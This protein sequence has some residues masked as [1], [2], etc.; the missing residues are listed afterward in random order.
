MPGQ[1]RVAAMH[2]SAKL[3][4]ELGAPLGRMHSATLALRVASAS[5]K[6]RAF[7]RWLGRTLLV[8][9]VAGASL[10]GCSIYD[11]PLL[12][13]NAGTSG[14]DSGTAGMSSAGGS[15]SSNAGDSSAGNSAGGQSE[16][17]AAG[18]SSGGRAGVGG[19]AD[20]S[21]GAAGDVGAGASSGNSGG[22]GGSAGGTAQAGNSGAG[23]GALV[24]REL[25]KGKKSTASTEQSGNEAVKGNDGD[26]DTRW[27]AS[28]ESYPQWWRVDLG[29][30]HQVVRVSIKFEHPER[31]YWY[32]IETSQ[33]DAVYVQ[34]AA[35]SGGT[36]RVQMVELPSNVTARY[37]RITL[38]AG[39]GAVDPTWA[40]FFEFAVTGA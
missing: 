11:A 40:S 18:D 10:L 23:G 3:K 7:E 14:D 33:D 28:S 13:G 26:S 39:S 35:L 30:S 1:G 6:R 25:A 5:S 31:K 22:N 38:T 9:S 4:T 19:L 12:G 24:V 15:A 29:S 21:A 36:G 8:L 34:Q 17:P 2:S 32:L 27:A 37:V 20:D 16:L